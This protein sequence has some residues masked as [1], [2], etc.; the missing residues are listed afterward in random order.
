MNEQ[1][2][3]MALILEV[4]V[5]DD[6]PQAIKVDPKAL[7]AVVV[8]EYKKSHDGKP[9][10]AE[11]VVAMVKEATARLEMLRP[12]AL[13]EIKAVVQKTL[14]VKDAVNLGFLIYANNPYQAKSKQPF[15]FKIDFSQVEVEEKPGKWNFKY[16]DR[17]VERSMRIPYRYTSTKMKDV[18]PFPDPDEFTVRDHFLVGFEGGSGY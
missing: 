14:S 4:R 15:A 12:L 17:H 16:G 13:L 18:S 8:E 3:I 11:Q 1:G 7:E 2:E 6:S 10:T 5:D 9:P